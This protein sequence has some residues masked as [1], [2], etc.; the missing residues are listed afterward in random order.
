MIIIKLN[1]LYTTKIRGIGGKLQNPE[2]FIVKEIIDRKFFS[3]YSRKNKVE[4]SEGKNSLVLLKKR[5]MTTHQAVKIIAEKYGIGKKE[6]SYAGLKDK[7][8]VTEQYM[9]I[10]K[11]VDGFK[12]DN[13]EVKVIGKTDKVL[14]VGDLIENNFEITLHNCKNIR[15]IPMILKEIYDKEIPNYFGPQR[16]STNN[17][18]IGKLLIKRK[19]DEAL[20]LINKNYEKR[21]NRI[22]KIE[23]N[24]LK[25]FIN[26]YQSYIFNESLNEILKTKR[27]SKDLPIVG[28]DTRSIP[29]NI[30]KILDR[31]RITSK[32]FEIKELNLSCRGGNRRTFINPD[33]KYKI[34]GKDV[35]FY[36]S[37]P[38]GSYATVVMKEISKKEFR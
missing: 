10:K 4:L 11:N 36:F 33:I 13:I 25:F 6:I 17:H 34:K 9:T 18:I 16:F 31:E 15:N 24:K 2:D 22:A 19:F 28:S 37:L 3:K 5:N 14:G 32:D 27:K 8:A 23:K 7:F 30:K 26:A 20:D 38:K 12:E 29:R 1:Y 35:T 21:Y